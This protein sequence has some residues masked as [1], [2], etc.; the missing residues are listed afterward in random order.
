MLLFHLNLASEGYT[1]VRKLVL[2][3]SFHCA[4]DISIT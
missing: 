3:K 4:V 1:R 2:E